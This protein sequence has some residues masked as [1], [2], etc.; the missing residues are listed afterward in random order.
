[1]GQAVEAAL[2]KDCWLELQDE[3]REVGWLYVGLLVNTVLTVT[4]PN[5]WLIVSRGNC[6]QA[7]PHK[8]SRSATKL[9]HQAIL[10]FIKNNAMIVK[11]G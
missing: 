7:G 1:M 3:R 11:I 10:K 8:H 9:K 5:N 6:S 4:Q 2:L